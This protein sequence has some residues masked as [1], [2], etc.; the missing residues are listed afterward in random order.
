MATDLPTGEWRHHPLAW[1]EQPDT[2]C[3]LC[4]RPLARR[5]FVASLGGADVSFCGPDC[6]LLYRKRRAVPAAGAGGG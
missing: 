6:E 5:R 2:H 1:W 3:E 4:G